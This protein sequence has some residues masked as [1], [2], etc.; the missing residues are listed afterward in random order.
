VKIGQI[1]ISKEVLIIAEVGSNHNGD[2]ETAKQLVCEAAQAGVHAV[3]FQTYKAENLIR[4]DVPVLTHVTGKHKFQYERFKSLEFSETQYEGLYSLAQGLKLMFISTPFDE[5]SADML[6]QWV[7]VFKI[8]SGDLTNLPL[9]RHVASKKKIVLLSTG[10]GDDEEIALALRQFE[11]EQ[12]VLLHCVS[13]YPTP[14]EKAN[15]FSIPYLRNK[16]N[17]P[18]GYSDHTIGGI[19]CLGAVALGAQVI[20]KHFTMNKDQLIGDHKLSLEPGDL[21]ELAVD[22]KNLSRALGLYSKP[23]ASESEMKGKMRR[24][25]VAKNGIKAGTILTPDMVIALRPE[26]GIPASKF[27]QVIGK[28]AK[29]NIKSGQAL[30]FDFLE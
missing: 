17:V 26:D 19:A 12:T 20:E 5:Q 6:N 16:F 25:L 23:V 30:Q 3:K 8:S 14:Y 22:V 24:S 11:Q 1:D 21:K 4:K 28:K 2:F 18:V 9:L 10:M 27:D 29:N 13:L 7:P 15:L